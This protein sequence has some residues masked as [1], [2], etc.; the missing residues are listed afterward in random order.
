VEVERSEQGDPGYTDLLLPLRFSVPAQGENPS[1]GDNKEQGKIVAQFTVF[2][3]KNQAQF[4]QTPQGR[5][6]SDEEQSPRGDSPPENGGVNSLPTCGLGRRFPAQNQRN[7]NCIEG[8]LC[9]L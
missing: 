1:R 7:A 2:T 5:L 8:F 4:C 3:V 6:E 9:H